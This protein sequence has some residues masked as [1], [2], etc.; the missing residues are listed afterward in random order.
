MPGDPHS[1]PSSAQGIG[2]RCT[3]CFSAEEPGA[4]RLLYVRSAEQEGEA[5]G[6]EELA[7]LVRNSCQ[8]GP[9]LFLRLPH[10]SR[11]AQRITVLLPTRRSRG[12]GKQQL[13]VR[14]GQRGQGAQQT[15]SCLYL[16][17]LAREGE[18]YGKTRQRAVGQPPAPA[19]AGTA[20]GQGA[21][22]LH[23]RKG[24]WRAANCFDLM[25]GGS[26]RARDRTSSSFLP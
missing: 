9:R 13:P 2:M 7:V 21:D 16:G 3:R 4:I 20:M 1:S 24:V 22:F 11:P 18:I 15:N 17:S 25:R 14:L 6:P 10:C 26:W 8:R 12:H 23:R 19:G 5:A